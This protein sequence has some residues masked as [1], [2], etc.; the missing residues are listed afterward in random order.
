M[1]KAN[2]SSVD[3]TE[4]VTIT[5]IA[6]WPTI[7]F[8]PNLMYGHFIGTAPIRVGDLTRNV[9]VRSSGTDTTSNTA[10]I[11]SLTGN[12]TSFNLVYGEFAY[13]GANISG[14][15]GIS[16]VNAYAT[17]SSCTVHDG[18][19][20]LL[21]GSNNLISN[22]L[23][24]KAV[25]VGIYATFNASNSRILNNDIYST[26]VQNFFANG[27]SYITV[28]GNSMYSAS[29]NLG[30]IFLANRSFLVV[31]NNS[32][33]NY[34]VGIQMN[35]SVGMVLEGN[36]T[37]ANFGGGFQESS[38]GVPAI[39]LADNYWGYSPTRASSPDSGAEYE[40]LSGGSP[41]IAKNLHV[42]PSGGFGSDGTPVASGSSLISYNQDFDTGTVRIFGD[43]LVSGSTLTLDYVN[44]LYASTASAA[45]VMVGVSISG[46]TINST[47]DTNA[48]SQLITVVWN[49]S[50]WQV[51]G[52]S[53]G[54]MGTFASLS[55]TPVPAST[56]QFNLTVT[57]S[58]PQPADEADFVL[59]AASNDSNRQ[60]KLYAATPFGTTSTNGHS[61][62]EIS[63]T[64]GFDA[65]GTSANPT[66]IDM[67]PSGGTYYTFV[68]TGAFTIIY[69]TITNTDT[70]GIQ[71]T[72][73]AGVS[74]SSS[75]FDFAGEG[76]SSTNT[77]ISAFSLTSASTFYGMTFNNS[78]SSGTFQYN[79]WA[80]TE[81][82]LSWYF[83]GW[84]GVRGGP[85]YTKEDPSVNHVTWSSVN[86][87][88][89][90]GAS[91]TLWSNS[92]NW[93]PAP[94]SCLPIGS[95]ATVIIDTNSVN[96][97][98]LDSTTTI[99]ALD[100]ATSGV[101]GSTL[102]MAAPITVSSGVILGAKGVITHPANAASQVYISSIAANYMTMSGLINV[103]GQGYA[104]SDGPGAAGCSITG[105]SYGG[106]GQTAFTPN[107]IGATYGS[108]SAPTQ[109]GSGG[110]QASG[111]GAVILNITNTLTDNGSILA[112]GNSSTSYGMGSGG[113]IYITANVLSGTGTLSASG[114]P[115][116]TSADVGGGGRI[117]VI[118]STSAF[119]G[120]IHAWGTAGSVTG[121]SAAG[122]VFI[123][124]PGTNGTLIID[125]NNNNATP[126]YTQISSGSYVGL[127][128]QVQLNH[129][130]NLQVQYPSTMT[131]TAS[132]ILGDGTTGY[133][134]VDGV[135]NL[136]TS[137]TMSGFGLVLSS[138]TTVSG[139]ASSL[140]IGG[141]SG[142]VITH[143][144]NSTAEVHKASMTL[145]NLTIAANGLID[146]TGRGY[147]A[148]YGP[149]KT[150]CSQTAGSYGGQGADDSGG[151]CIGATYGS[152]SAPVNLGSGGYGAAGGGAVILNI[153]NTLQVNGSILAPG[154]VANTWLSGSGGSVY[155]QANVLTGT[156]TISA[157]GGNGGGVCGG[158]G[159][160]GRA[161]VIAS[162]SGFSGSLIAYGGAGGSYGPGAAGTIFIKTPGT[163]GTLIVNNNNLVPTTP[164]GLYTVLGTTY[165]AGAYTFDSILAQ[166][167]SS[168]TFVSYSTVTIAG[169]DV[170]GDG[171]FTSTVTVNG[172]F[173]GGYFSA[174]DSCNGLT[175]VWGSS[176]NPGAATYTLQVSSVANYS[177]TILSS[178]TA[179][180]SATIPAGSVTVG[181]T[182]YARV[183]PNA[184]A[185]TTIL[186]NNYAVIGSTVVGTGV[187]VGT[188]TW[189]GVTNTTWS[190]ASNWSPSCA[191]PGPNN[192]VIIDTNSANQ[193]TLNS[194]TTI[195][196]LYIATSGVYGSTM[197]MTAPLTVS[198]GVTVGAMGV[199][200]HPAN[201]TTQ[202]YISSIAANYMTVTGQINVTGD[203][204][205]NGQ[206]PGF[207]PGAAA[208]YGGES[209]SCFGQTYGAYNAPITIG[210]GSNTPGG[211]AIILNI[212]N[213]LQ[214][215]G[216]LLAN[217]GAG[218]NNSGSGR[219]HLHYGLRIERKRGPGRQR[220]AR[221]L[222]R[223]HCGDCE[224]E[225]IQRQLP[226]LWDLGLQR[227]RRS[228][229]DF[230]PNDG[231]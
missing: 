183:V 110:G 225:R 91:N 168:M 66:L 62:I 30:A 141:S 102:T 195:Y 158:G 206:G 203:G 133:I 219:K 191:A 193:P 157:S 216:S 67:L 220:R 41:L 190:V 224:H 105:G 128:D 112:D 9:V 119:A 70:S 178:T 209:D 20:G 93:N 164:A 222:R 169:A 166:G 198:S 179:N 163:N 194:T 101:Y 72:G 92:A 13:F 52:S 120:A 87:Y 127:F 103:T 218:S 139:S 156:G 74:M 131:W 113:S 189:T 17:I 170:F 167:K 125:N 42:N 90:T 109:L 140:T 28:A 213:T 137:M 217:G 221:S 230:H 145:S 207:C 201:S 188:M 83:S 177:G 173:N 82:G 18:Y 22:N 77:Y 6:S 215:N 124:T 40:I 61:K 86:V 99:Y 159:G 144:Y 80:S 162:T 228:W 23:I 5:S 44:Q 16:L 1:G 155:I 115:N 43:Y 108:Y 45:N 36:R 51:T 134:R 121:G 64:G 57:A 71:L 63:S 151:S 60:K 8:S 34:G 211:G 111:G 79:V 184:Y 231:E 7:S 2:N 118:A 196:A 81:A 15:E 55:N 142:A 54:S 104:T 172:N 100:I 24:Y 227:L 171:D 180:R 117:A 33:S 153:I 187:V 197:T 229:D 200:T 59:L 160:G 26:A 27:P 130:G 138:I 182:Y 116:S 161:A 65:E 205:A 226:G 21:P 14:K 94:Q 106:Q 12:A 214:L 53:T 135:L 10:Y 48:V 149:G 212:T 208:S 35:S 39:V 96:Q 148:G 204:Y 136:P 122:T 56:T 50:A 154:A 107:C 150:L 98:V 32:Y 181:T 165:T 11:Q 73:S 88:R 202:V 37:F 3:E 58:S 76:T 49:G 84:S 132:N 69:A 152:Y 97:P 78:R 114:A 4:R 210:S 47:N 147:A 174:A 192:T 29:S 123:K 31:N 85:C 176:P 185:I 199:I 126:L 129:Q 75:T 68:D 186:P 223:P 19:D 46:V 89:W 143:E 38:N 175:A 146:V 95:A 25:S